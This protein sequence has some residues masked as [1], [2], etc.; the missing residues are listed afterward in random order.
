METYNFNDVI[1]LAACYARIII[2]HNST[3]SRARASSLLDEMRTPV[4][5]SQGRTRATRGHSFSTYG[6]KGGGGVK[7][8]AYANVLFP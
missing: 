3:E 5:S 8:F 7:R 1:L 6:P 4:L 2:T